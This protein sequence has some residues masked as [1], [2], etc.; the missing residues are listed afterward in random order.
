MPDYSFPPSQDTMY[1]L[2]WAS[3]GLDQEQVILVWD[4]CSYSTSWARCLQSCGLFYNKPK[5]YAFSLMLRFEYK[6]SLFG[7][8]VEGSHRLVFYGV[9][10]FYN[11]PIAWA[12]FTCTHVLNDPLAFPLALFLTVQPSFSQ[13]KTVDSAWIASPGGN[14]GVLPK[15]CGLLLF[16]LLSSKVG[17]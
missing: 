4:Y 10:P 6:L 12:F 5:A 7:S 9:V 14:A 15:Y 8:I 3:G 13:E 11:K 1:S 2:A 17:I 16:Y